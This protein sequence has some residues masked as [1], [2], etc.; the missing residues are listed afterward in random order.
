M[1]TEILIAL[2]GVIVSMIGVI[3]AII[4]FWKQ[5]RDTHTS[6]GVQLL[7]A[8]EKDFDSP[9]MRKDRSALARLYRKHRLGT[10]LSG[11]LFGD[12]SQIFDFFTTV[13]ML[14]KR[15]V[16]DVEFVWTSFYYWFVRHWEVSE[17][18]I[19]AWRIKAGDET[20]WEECDYLYKR[21]V[22][23]GAG[24]RGIPAQRQTPDELIRFIKEQSDLD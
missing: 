7:R 5:T 22:R 21:L 8:F 10:P 14:L 9:E 4:A 2:G 6:L 16:L 24:R 20:Y 18:D 15:G 23:Y 11:S 17:V 1:A 19:R 3:V 12:H 13:G